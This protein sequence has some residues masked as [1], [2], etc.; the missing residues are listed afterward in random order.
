MKILY[1]TS[2]RLG[3]A[4][5]STGL[6]RHFEEHYP[7]AEVTVAC[8]GL[9]ESIFAPAPVVTRVIPMKKRSWS[10]HWLDLWR[11]CRTTHWDMIVDIRNSAVSRVLRGGKKY[12]FSGKGDNRLHKVEQM[13]AVMR[14]DVPPAPKLWFSPEQVKTAQQYI[15]DETMPVLGIGPAANWIGKI[16]QT[17]RFAELV[18][19]LTAKDGILPDAP[20]AVF[21]APGEE[22]IAYKLLET[23]PEARRIDVIAKL[24]PGTAAAVI[25][26]CALFVG[27]DSGLMHCAA[28]ADVPSVGLFGHGFPAQYRPWG[29]HCTYVR[30][31]EDP[32]ELLT[33]SGVDHPSLVTHSL[34]DS[35]SVDMVEEA[36]T[37]HWHK[38]AGAADKKKAG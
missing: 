12:I 21:A 28:A 22:E 13:A 36:V 16:W 4:V 11:D 2:N 31:P 18:R 23:I 9:A 29:D 20:V 7:D 3:D 1:I 14:L 38:T 5:L 37:K 33:A 32:A 30:T 8:G 34:M 6:V 24:D 17:E 19:R 27:N 35:L 25:S 26:R 10:R 15:A